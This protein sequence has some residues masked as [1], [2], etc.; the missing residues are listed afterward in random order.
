MHDIDIRQ[1]LILAS[2]SPY[3]NMLLKRLG[4]EFSIVAP[5]FDES[6]PALA[7]AHPMAPRLSAA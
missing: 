5:S 4:M 1:E 3:R 2:T 7:A 6:P